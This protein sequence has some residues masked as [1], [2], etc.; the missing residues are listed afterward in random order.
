MEYRPLT[1]EQKEVLEES[2]EYDL[3][4]DFSGSR[5]PSLANRLHEVFGENIPNIMSLN[6]KKLRFYEIITSR[7][8]KFI[9]NRMKRR[10]FRGIFGKLERAGYKGPEGLGMKDS[11]KMDVAQMWD[12]YTV[13]RKDLDIFS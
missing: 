1:V 9:Y 3:N 6:K 4:T 10:N 11:S 5:G 13:I 8:S 2:I 7:D 12:Y